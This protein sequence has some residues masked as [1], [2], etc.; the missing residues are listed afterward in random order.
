MATYKYQITDKYGKDKKG[1][2]EAA[3]PEAATAKLKGDGAVVR[4]VRE[5]TSIDDAAWNITIGNPVKMK[6]ITLFCRQFYSILNAGVTVVDGLKMLQDSTEN[7]VF[8]KSIYNVQVNVEKGETLANAMALEG[9]V[10]PDLL[11]NMVAAG[12]AT[13]N[14]SIAFE[15]ICTQFEK[16]S[17]LR[18]MLVSAMIY[19]IVV[20]VVTIIVVIVL[21]VV[22][23]PQF[24]EIFDM[25]G[26]ELPLPTQ[27][28]INV[29][30]FMINNLVLVIGGIVGLV[31]AVIAAKNTEMGK[32]LT[33]RMCLK[34]PIINDFTVKNGSAKFSMTMSTLITSGVPLVEALGIVA[35]VVQNRVMRKALNDAREEVMQ[36][37]PMSEPLEAS[38]VFPQMVHHMVRIGEETGN[39][40]AMLDKVAEYYEQ[41]VEAA[42]KNLTTIMEPLII[43]VL[44][45]S[46]GGVVGAIVMP[47]M[48]IYSMTG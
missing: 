40:E 14:L 18:S 11:I 25:M 24:Q 48:Q 6:D 46:V 1:T 34:L 37:I 12:E 36:G 35:N 20:L 29:S 2:L 21:M 31:L 15:R 3:S 28:V 44:A 47:M 26:E 42:T 13:G 45:I 41:E 22:V 43:I 30:Q 4:S 10:F 9:K 17:K 38:G 23:I 32:Q 39:T 33:S 8:R 16:D 5:V 19:P 7:K 27:I